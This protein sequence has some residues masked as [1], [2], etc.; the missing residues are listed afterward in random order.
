MT[1]SDCC[2]TV[3]EILNT[4]SILVTNPIINESRDEREICIA[5]SE[6]FLEKEDI[7]THIMFVSIRIIVSVSLPRINCCFTSLDRLFKSALF[8]LCRS[9]HLSR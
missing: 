8:D 7:Y 9:R 4:C 3:L 1:H 2:V 5:L 6:L